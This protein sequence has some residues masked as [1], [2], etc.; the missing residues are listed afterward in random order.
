MNFRKTT[1]VV[2]IRALRS[3]YHTLRK[4]VLDSFFC[5]MVKADAYGHGAAVVVRTLRDEGLRRFGVA[6]IEEAVALRSE[7]F[8]DEE[9]LVFGAFDQSGAK[10]VVSHKLTPVLS[11]IDQL[12]SLLAILPDGGQFP[13]HL[14]LN[15][16]MNRLGFDES[17]WPQMQSR[18]SRQSRLKVVG[19][20]THLISS[21]DAGL[22]DGRS[23]Q[24]RQ[25]FLSWVQRHFAGETPELHVYNS[26][27]ALNQT[28]GT[29]GFRP[30]ISLYGVVPDATSNPVAKKL[31]PVMSLKSEIVKTH[32]IQ[33]GESVSYGGRWVAQRPS[34]IAA[35]AIGYA[36]GLNRGLSQGGEM[37]FRGQR[38]PIVGTI[39]M[40][41]TMIDITDVVQQA[42]P[43]PGEEVVVFG[44]QLDQ[45]LS[46]LEIARKLNTI[47][48]EIFVNIS[49]RVPRELKA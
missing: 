42:S 41:T 39:C 23:Q 30:G 43:M 20:C 9:F 16:G 1:A 49:A 34:C 5:P 21:E 31:T 22:M 35:V 26:M 15:T 48:Y 27:G 7:G 33:I 11:R 19:L 46:V 14:K 17:E 38:V 44:R 18:L 25:A 40:D 24:Q 4:L 8:K 10:A 47:A 13:V 32:R 36:D 6:L 29:E 2:D 28:G 37:L 45:S 12:D 3:N